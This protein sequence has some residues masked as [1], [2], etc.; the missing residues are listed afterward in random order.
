MIEDDQNQLRAAMIHFG[1]QYSNELNDRVTHMCLLN[2]EG[3][4]Y[5]KLIQHREWTVQLVLPHWIDDCV[6]LRRRLPETD[7]LFPKVNI[8]KSR[9]WMTDLTESDV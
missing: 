8:L 9:K 2:Q 6:K 7:Y 1:G 4:M 3:E 5:R